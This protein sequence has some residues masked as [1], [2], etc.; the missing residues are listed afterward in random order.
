MLTK[1]KP[2]HC[3]PV[4][5][6]I[7]SPIEV[8]ANFGAIIQWRLDCCWAFLRCGVG[9]H[10]TLPTNRAG[11]YYPPLRSIGY[12]NALV[13]AAICRPPCP[14]DCFFQICL[15]QIWISLSWFESN[16]KNKRTEHIRQYTILVGLH[17][18]ATCYET[19]HRTVS[20]KF[21]FAKFGAACRWFESNSKKTKRTEHIRQY[22][23]LVGLQGCATCYET[24]HRTVSPKFAI[25]QIWSSRGSSPIQKNKKN[26]AHFLCAPFFSPPSWTRTNDPAVNSR[27]LYQLSY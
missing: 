1:A 6:L 14:L 26:G 13:G 12:K 22:T 11:G 9:L 17:G 19:V 16:S 8:Y 18:C 5:F 2:H 24:V 7:Q 21:V 27:M 20:S 3:S 23:I 4:L 10:P 15:R 25:M